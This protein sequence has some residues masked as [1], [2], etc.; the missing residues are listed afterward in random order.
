MKRTTVSNAIWDTLRIA[1]SSPIYWQCRIYCT[2]LL[3]LAILTTAW[4]QTTTATETAT[5]ENSTYAPFVPEVCCGNSATVVSPSSLTTSSFPARAGSKAAVVTWSQ[6]IWDDNGNSSSTRRVEFRSNKRARKDQWYGFSFYL[7]S[8]FP[9]D[10]NMI[11]AQLIAYSNDCPTDKSVVLS[12]RG[13][14]LTLDGYKGSGSNETLSVSTPLTSTVARGRWVDVIIHAR[15]SNQSKGLL[16]VWFDGAG[17]V[18]P[19][20]RTTGINLSTGCFDPDDSLRYGCYPKFGLYCYDTARYTAGE[21][22]T[23]YFDE[24]RWLDGNP[25]NAYDL[26]RP[27]STSGGGRLAALTPETVATPLVVTPKSGEIFTVTVPPDLLNQ[28]FA[29]VNDRG[30]NVFAGHFTGRQLLVNLQGLPAGSYFIKTNNGPSVPMQ[31][32]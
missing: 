8:T 24:V 13:T 29:V 10:K 22:R 16:E 6:Q 32:P 5:F 15:Y 7:P 30:K 12:L 31:K 17:R 28:P 27:R 19:T 9:T 14:S 2:A 20:G 21:I 11:L 23:A 25:V 1:D 18:N 4:A 3:M 26:V